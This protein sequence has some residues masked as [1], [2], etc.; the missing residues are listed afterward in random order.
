MI[1][2]C[3]S[4]ALAHNDAAI[5]DDACGPTPLHLEARYNYEDRNSVAGFVD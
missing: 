4:M 5:A 2:L 1:D 3:P